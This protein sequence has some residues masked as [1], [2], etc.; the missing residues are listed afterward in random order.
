MSLESILEQVG[1]PNPADE[2]FKIIVEGVT[3][4]YTNGWIALDDLYT[5]TGDCSTQPPEATIAPP[6]T[7]TAAPGYSS[8][9]LYFIVTR[10]PFIYSQTPYSLF[11]H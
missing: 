6:A 4:S 3:G 2:G 7:T 5:Y 9:T 11:G 1:I 8:W 10:F